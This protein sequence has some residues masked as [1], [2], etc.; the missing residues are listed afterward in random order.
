MAKRTQSASTPKSNSVALNHNAA[1]VIRKKLKPPFGELRS[2]FA[3]TSIARQ[4]TRDALP[5]LLAQS[6]L[7]PVEQREVQ[8]A[9]AEDLSCFASLDEIRQLCS[10]SV[11]PTVLLCRQ[12]REWGESFRATEQARQATQAEPTSATGAIQ[13]TG[14][15]TAKRL[16]DYAGC[17]PRQ[18]RDVLT[19]CPVEVDSSRRKSWRYCDALPF[20]RK[21]CKESTHNK[22]NKITWPDIADF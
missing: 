6:Q 9:F 4:Q 11:L 14:Y 12:R 3:R 19:N 15:V 1:D 10:D 5:S 16:A 8:E 17:E 2:L 22:F 7:T 20:L 18:I 13:D 21:W